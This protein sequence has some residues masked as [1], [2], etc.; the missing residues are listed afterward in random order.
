MD[1]EDVPPAS[2]TAPDFVSPVGARPFRPGLA[3]KVSSDRAASKRRTLAMLGAA[4]VV[5]AVSLVLPNEDAPRSTRA[6]LD[7]PPPLEPTER[8]FDVRA[9][10]PASDATAQREEDAAS[11]ENAAPAPAK[12]TPVPA[13]TESAFRSPPPTRTGRII[14]EDP[15]VQGFTHPSR[16]GGGARIARGN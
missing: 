1:E 14:R 7:P 2:D 8:R 4:C 12:P 3:T 11:T 6:L 10:V 15:Y 16:L 13:L 5:A 9:A